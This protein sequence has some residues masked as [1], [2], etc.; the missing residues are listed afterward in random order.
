MSADVDPVLFILDLD[1]KYTVDVVYFLVIGKLA[2]WWKVNVILY[3][4]ILCSLLS[5]NSESM[6]KTY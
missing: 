3:I 2:L 6:Y 1:M 5:L 4:H